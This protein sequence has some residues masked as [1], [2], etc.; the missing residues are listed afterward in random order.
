M[1]TLLVQTEVSTR[2]GSSGQK[3][4]TEILVD[5]EPLVDFARYWLAVDL[6]QLALSLG[7][8]GE[9]YVITC[10]CGAAG[11][12]GIWRGIEVHHDAGRVHWTVRGLEPVRTFVFDGRAYLEAIEEGLRHF[13]QLRVQ[14][15]RLDVIP[16]QNRYLHKEWSRIEAQLAERAAPKLETA[17]YVDQVPLWPAEG[18]HILAHYDETS[19]VVYQAFRPEI[20]AY[21]V[22]HQQLGGGF[23]FRRMSWIKPSFLWMMYRSRWGSKP[24]QEMVLAVRIKRD[25]FDRVLA[26][27]VP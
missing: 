23:K 1:N 13:E 7:G 20:G 22:E 3:L 5:N 16:F 18:R 8:D 15:Q 19:I 6:H 2:E 11:C 10:V 21:A 26:Q 27:A 17:R 14:H 12:A 4:R 24:G 9:Y 25:F